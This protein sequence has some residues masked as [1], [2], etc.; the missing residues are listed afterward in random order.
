[1]WRDH[2]RRYRI[3]LGV[4]VMLM[5]LVPIVEAQPSHPGAQPPTTVRT[6]TYSY[7][8]AGRLSRADYGDGTAILYLYDSG[9]NMLS[10]RIVHVML[11]YL[12]LVIKTR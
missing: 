6:I 1:M 3:V 2:D 5:A 12:P 11:V 10:R 4:L 8:A 7:D 9:G